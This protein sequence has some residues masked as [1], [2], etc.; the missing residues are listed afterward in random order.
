MG[1]QGDNIKMGEEGALTTI[2]ASNSIQDLSF[3]S[4]SSEQNLVKIEDLHKPQ[5][6]AMKDLAKDISNYDPADDDDPII[7]CGRWAGALYQN[8]QNSK[9]A[10]K[11]SKTEFLN[12]HVGHQETIEMEDLGKEITEVTIVRWAGRL[13]QIAKDSED[14]VKESEK[15][16]QR[17][18]EKQG[19]IDDFHAKAQ[20]RNSCSEKDDTTTIPG[21]K[22]NNQNAEAEAS[23]SKK[24]K[25][26]NE[27]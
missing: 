15:E 3:T 17:R 23:S 18:H 14:A 9:N 6:Q 16:F 22:R 7:T 8:A 1:E 21:N 13:Y 10:I 19:K 11:D 4:G 5:I 2:S 12:K 20:A 25:R 26:S 24:I 27:N